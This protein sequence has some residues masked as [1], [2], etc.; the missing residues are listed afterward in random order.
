MRCRRTPGI[1]TQLSRVN[2]EFLAD[3]SIQGAP[4]IQ[5]DLGRRTLRILL[6]QP[7]RL[8]DQSELMLLG[9]GRLL[10]LFG[11]SRDL[12]LC[13]LTCVGHREPFAQRHGTGPR[14]QSRQAS[15]E[16]SMVSRAG[17]GDSHHPTKIRY[18]SIVG[19]QHCCTQIVA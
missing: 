14:D 4:L 18:Q 1:A 9:G 16:D 17:T 7:L 12:C 8:Q 6:G 15:D 11:L 3:Q 10:Q 5:H 13:E 19:A 2:P